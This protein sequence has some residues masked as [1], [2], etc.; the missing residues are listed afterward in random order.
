[1]INNHY[2]VVCL[3]FACVATALGELPAAF[4]SSKEVSRVLPAIRRPIQDTFE[5][6]EDE[7]IS[8]KNE[9]IGLLDSVA[10]QNLLIRG[11]ELQAEGK[12]TEDFFAKA[13]VSA[14]EIYFLRCFLNRVPLYY[15]GNMIVGKPKKAF[16]GRSQLP[17]TDAYFEATNVTVN[18]TKA[19]HN[20]TYSHP[21][22]EIVRY[23]AELTLRGWRE[24]RSRRWFAWQDTA[25]L[26]T[27]WIDFPTSSISLGVNTNA[28]IRSTVVLDRISANGFPLPPMSDSLPILQTLEAMNPRERLASLKMVA[29][30]GEP[31]ALFLLGY[32]YETG[33][34]TQTNLETSLAFYQQAA[35]RH[36][37]PALY[38]VGEAFYTGRGTPR[39]ISSAKKALD[40][41]VSLTNLW[42]LSLLGVILTET[43]N[44]ALGKEYIDYGAQCGIP[45]ASTKLA[46]M[47]F[48]NRSSSF[49]NLLTLLQGPLWNQSAEAALLLSRI[50]D[51]DLP[52]AP[53]KV[54]A[55]EWAMVAGIWPTSSY[56]SPSNSE[57]EQMIR[58]LRPQLKQTQLDLCIAS[59]WERLGSNT[60]ILRD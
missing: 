59:V 23:K 7:F 53:D 43:D 28:L 52:G 42:C 51:S 34:S 2:R 57:R 41:G 4:Q 50:Y 60:Q 33:W 6:V 14:A 9:L 55:L 35:R 46:E 11:I 31:E 25:H 58:I 21:P 17:P 3:A 49:T 10:L 56:A 36:F 48:A 37:S 38:K 40:V 12:L 18:V 45:I 16:P 39:N 8:F 20:L 27:F 19:F 30:R 47:R 54:K 22:M 5:K 13:S 24:Y 1:M 29:D 26:G 32:A 15:R 44:L